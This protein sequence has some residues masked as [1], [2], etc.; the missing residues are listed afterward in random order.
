MSDVSHAHR[1]PAFR[2]GCCRCSDSGKRGGS[3]DC[4]VL[5]PRC[6]PGI[7]RSPG[8]PSGG[9]RSFRLRPFRLRNLRRFR[10]PFDLGRRPRGKRGQYLPG[11]GGQRQIRA[12]WIHPASSRPGRTKG[13]PKEVRPEMPKK[14]PGTAPSGEAGAWGGLPGRAGSSRQSRPGRDKKTEQKTRVP[15]KAQ[16][17]QKAPWAERL[18]SGE[19][20]PTS[21]HVRDGLCGR[22]FACRRARRTE[23]PANRPPSGSRSRSPHPGGRT[24]ELKH[25]GA[26]ECVQTDSRGGQS[27]PVRPVRI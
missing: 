25:T 18:T 24:V 20:A 14:A 22:R 23:G 15:Q 10:S 11:R 13:H 17:Q 9:S 5:V 19:W 7:G 6:Q 21:F 26:A 8:R 12:R 1:G 4:R 3:H 2:Y 16:I 27:P